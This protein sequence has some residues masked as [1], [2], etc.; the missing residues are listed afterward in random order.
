[1]N[2]QGTLERERKEFSAA[3][4]DHAGKQNC[5]EE[6]DALMDNGSGL[7]GEGGDHFTESTHSTASV[8]L[9]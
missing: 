1:M 6:S 7:R 2:L 9:F 8:I 5:D 4:S 3:S